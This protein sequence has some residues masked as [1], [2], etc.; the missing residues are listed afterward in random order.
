MADSERLEL[1][2]RRAKSG[3]EFRPVQVTADPDDHD[4]LVQH[5]VDLARTQDGRGDDLWWL[6]EYE[7]QVRGVDRAWRDFV[8]KGPGC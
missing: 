4:V 7:M 3:T 2:L 8:V 6:A 5:L 1:T